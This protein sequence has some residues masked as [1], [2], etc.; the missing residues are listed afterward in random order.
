MLQHVTSKIF[1]GATGIFDNA[2]KQ[3]FC[4]WSRSFLPK[5]NWWAAYAEETKRKIYSLWHT[6]FVARSVNC[7]RAVRSQTLFKLT[8][9]DE[10]YS[11]RRFCRCR[12]QCVA[13]VK[14]ENLFSRGQPFNVNRCPRADRQRLV[15]KDL[16][17]EIDVYRWLST[18]QFPMIGFQLWISEKQLVK[19]DIKRSCFKSAG[20]LI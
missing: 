17:P 9:F 2:R 6:S 19:I 10:I 18:D 15:H 8:T 5:P 11:F 20:L 4:R 14:C 7:A 1:L 3:W 13:H 16:P 12:L